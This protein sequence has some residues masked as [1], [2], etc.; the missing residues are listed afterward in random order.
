VIESLMNRSCTLVRRTGSESYDELGNE[1]PSTEEVETRCA[2]QQRER[3]ENADEISETS[4]LLVLPAEEAIDTSDA[5]VIDG[6][7]Y[8]LAGAPAQ[9][10]DHLT[11]NISHIEA[12]IVRASSA[13]DSS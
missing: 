11:G 9:I 3:S 10:E 2:F 7:S 8:E 13:E 1:I 4:Y 5:V 12:T 6:V